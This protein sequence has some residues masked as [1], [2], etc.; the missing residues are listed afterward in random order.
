MMKH[1]SLFLPLL[2]LLILVPACG[3]GE[4]DPSPAMEAFR[5]RMTGKYL[6]ARDLLDFEDLSNAKD[7]YGL[8]EMTRTCFFLNELDMAYEVAKKLLRLEPD[9]SRYLFWHGFITFRLNQTRFHITDSL[10]RQLTDEAM[11]S[12]RRALEIDPFNHAA[13]FKLIHLLVCLGP[14][15]G[16]DREE[17]ARVAEELVQLD[18]GW[19]TYAQGKTIV[20]GKSWDAIV[21]KAGKIL[22]KDPE[23]IGALLAKAEGTMHSG[24]PLVAEKQI[25]KLIS[26]DPEWSRFYLNLAQT[27]F[28]TEDFERSYTWVDKYRSDPNL[29]HPEKARAAFVYAMIQKRH[30]GKEAWAKY[31][32]IACQL[33][34]KILSRYQV[35]P[36]DLN[37]PP[38]EE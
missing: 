2:A 14:D 13:R 5:L 15:D 9:D 25:E 6:E 28:R 31:M 17:A 22:E 24:D 37:K 11:D 27:A 18:E 33:D 38:I 34:P 36:W 16:R 4:D 8:F 3:P 23:N 12:F 26:I 30:N 7:V 10:D 21:E 35:S 1:A 20:P 32:K 29:I 19:G